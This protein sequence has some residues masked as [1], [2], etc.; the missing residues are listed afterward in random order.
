MRGGGRLHPLPGRGLTLTILNQT[1]DS[2]PN[3]D[4][5]NHTV[6]FP[7]NRV[8][9]QPDKMCGFALTHKQPALSNHVQGSNL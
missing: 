4:V 5:Y 3:L 9:Q 7:I 6:Y 8:L 1:N 2:A